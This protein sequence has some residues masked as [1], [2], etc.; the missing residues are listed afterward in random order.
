MTSP[1][2]QAACLTP[3]A[4]GGIALIQVVGRN[5]IGA[6][7]PH[8]L[9]GQRPVDLAQWRADEL[10]LCRLVDGSETIDDAVVCVRTNES[11]EQVIDLNLHGGARIVQRALLMLQREGVRI[12]EPAEL[13]HTCWPTPT[14]LAAKALPLLLTARTRR[15]AVWLAR[16]PDLLRERVATIIAAVRSGPPADAVAALDSLLADARRA[17]L[18][19]HGV[20]AVLVGKPN[21]GKSTLA[22]ALAEREHAVVSD[23]PGTTRDW[24]EHP[25]AIEGVPFTIVDT[26]GIRHTDDPIEAEAIARARRQVLTAHVIIR[27]NDLTQPPDK[28]DE[29]LF[30]T[31]G[32]AAG[33]QTPLVD[34]YN[35]VDLP[36]HPKQAARGEGK[37]SV[38]ISARTGQ[39]IDRLRS[40]LLDQIGLPCQADWPAA[41]FTAE[42]IECCRQAKA[43]LTGVSPDRPRAVDCLEKMRG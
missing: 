34:V 36:V 39:G 26:A 29:D 41:P 9:K 30:G 6:V 2:P 18:L 21:S 22:N 12:V 43:A 1:P 24:T 33:E 23:T 10:R 42:Q 3:P 5:A 31:D 19:I 27:V 38:R 16:L 35:K 32:Q 20:R 4:I 25:A 15:T 8:L 13:L 40:L 14:R 11:G 7:N 17:Q 28:Q 37:P